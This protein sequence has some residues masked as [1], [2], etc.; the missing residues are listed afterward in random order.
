MSGVTAASALSKLKAG[1]KRY[2]A[3]KMKREMQDP[4]RRS[5]LTEGQSPF[6]IVLSCADSR[7]R[8]GTRV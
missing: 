6:A 3:D 2:V 4:T 5:D 1:N 8:T 7:G